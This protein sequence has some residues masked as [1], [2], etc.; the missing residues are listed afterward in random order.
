MKYAR[1]PFPIWLFQKFCALAKKLGWLIRGE[2]WKFLD[3][4]L[5]HAAAHPDLFRKR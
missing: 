1:P 4:M 2:R 5:D 3:L